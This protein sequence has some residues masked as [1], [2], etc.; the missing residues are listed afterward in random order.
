VDSNGNITETDTGR[1][2]LVANDNADVVFYSDDVTSGEQYVGIAFDNMSI[3]FFFPENQN[4]PISMT[5]SDS[6]ES[7]NGYFTPY[8]TDTQTY[9]LAI[10]QGGDMEAYLDIP[11][12]KNTFTQYRDD[13]RLTQSQNLRMRNL[14]IA[15]CIF[16]SL[17]SV[18][19]S[20]ST[21]QARG[22]FDFITKPLAKFFSSTV[23]KLVTGVS[24]AIVGVAVG[25][26]G[27]VTFNPALMYY[28]SYATAFGLV[29]L[30]QGVY[31]LSTSHASSGGPIPV[32]GVM[33][34]KTAISMASNAT[35]TLSATIVPYY[36]ANTNVTWSSSNPAVAAVSSGGV[37]TSYNEGTAVV[38]VKTVD[39]NKTADC[40]V[41]VAN[42]FNSV[43][44]V[45]NKLSW[46]ETG[47]QSGGNYLIEVYADETISSQVLSYSGKSNIT[48]T[49]R[50]VGS[51]RT[52]SLASAGSMFITVGSGVTLILDNNITLRGLS[53]NY[54]PLVLLENNGTLIMNTGSTISGNFGNSGGGVYIAQDGSFIMNGGT[55]SGNSAGSG[56]GGGVLIGGGTF[57]MNGGTISGN[58]AN[59][60]FPAYGGGVSVSIGTFTMNGG[61]ISGNTATGNPTTAYGGG[62]SVHGTFTMNGGT[63]SG[64][65][66]GSGGGVFVGDG[67][68]ETFTM[69]G[70][71][72]SGNTAGSG[73]GVRVD[74]NSA[75]FHMV[76]GTIYGN[77]EANVSLR[78]T[79][80]GGGAAL[81][82]Y[83]GFAE[84]GTFTG[85]T[86]KSNGALS[87]TDNTIKVAN[88]ILA[89]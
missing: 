26:V 49:L 45:A 23:G 83:R 41:T 64:N 57:T 68:N 84:R 7:Y 34:N 39:G 6:M 54:L 80:T 52:I 11:L 85:T 77:G 21:R 53:N 8:D 38:T 28:G 18:F 32:V 16:K 25:I 33:S 3:V 67:Y 15:T 63:I 62:V 86:W 74:S 56:G 40:T 58:T 50:G 75:I 14:Y 10:E 59:T 30:T 12:N 72:I 69:N 4:F 31:E 79:A 13:A 48:I 44:G 66:A 1:T 5:L 17:E 22:L 42:D 24:A 60:T 82:A 73:G 88:G 20:D 43:K 61:T 55:I 9:S 2:A 19:A 47:A 37:V 36:A 70:G 46:L 78:N 81:Y 51:N 35:Y 27:I 29:Y 76:T 87:T 65:T 89:P 71:T